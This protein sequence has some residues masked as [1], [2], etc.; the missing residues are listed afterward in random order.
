MTENNEVLNSTKE[1]PTKKFYLIAIN[2]Q[3]CLEIISK[4][5][6]VLQVYNFLV[7]G[8]KWEIMCFNRL[9][10]SQNFN[11]NFAWGEDL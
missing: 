1:V 4:L 5:K 11:C 6:W 7:V 9:Y 8:Y 3:E 2:E 10:N